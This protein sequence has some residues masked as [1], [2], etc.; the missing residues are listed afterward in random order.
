MQDIVEFITEKRKKFG[1]SKSI[2][3]ANYYIYDPYFLWSCHMPVL[4][5]RIY[6]KYN[7]RQTFN[8]VIH[9]NAIYILFPM[10]VLFACSSAFLYLVSDFVRVSVYL[11]RI[12]A[13]A[14]F[15][16]IIVWVI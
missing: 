13:S 7:S 12:S 15:Y 8:A 16:S 4:M 2:L 3:I 10:R 6:H 9:C 1:Y 5:S 14:F 11:S